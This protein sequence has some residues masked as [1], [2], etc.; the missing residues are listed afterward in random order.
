MTGELE[1]YADRKIAR[2]A[3]KVPRRFRA[4]AVCD[5]MFT[6][7]KR[8]ESKF[9]TCTITIPL[10]GWSIESKETTQHMYAA[11]DIAVVHVEQQLK[12]YARTQRRGILHRRKDAEV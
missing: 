5:V 2:L 3:R 10:D 11:L 9:S 8:K 7:T 1:K 6:Q 4:S 12:D